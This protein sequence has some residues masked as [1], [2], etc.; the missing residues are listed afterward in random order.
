MCLGLVLKPALAPVLGLVLGLVLALVLALVL[1]FLL[2]V[3]LVMGLVL[4]VGLVLGLGLGLVLAVQAVVLFAVFDPTPHNGGDNAGYITLAHSLVDRGAYLELWDPE[5]P[6]HTK[7]PPGF[8]L[9]LAVMMA[10]VR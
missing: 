10:L 6:P 8:P 3:G 5:E 4:A 7:Y 9:V 1:G 2:G